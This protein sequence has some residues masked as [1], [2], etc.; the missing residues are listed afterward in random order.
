MESEHIRQAT[1]CNL[2]NL[3][4]LINSILVESKTCLWE[5]Q[6]F[7][8][9]H[10]EVLHQDKELLLLCFGQNGGFSAL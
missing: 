8:L 5:K 9:L 4:N 2:T 7:S 6:F 10:C 1:T 3:A